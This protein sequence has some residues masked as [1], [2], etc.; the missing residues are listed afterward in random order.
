MSSDCDCCSHERDVPHQRQVV[1]NCGW[2]GRVLSRRLNVE[3]PVN[4]EDLTGLSTSISGRSPRER[5]IG[6]V[7]AAGEG[8]RLALGGYPKELMPILFRRDGQGRV[9]PELA[10]EHC[11]R[12][13]A[14]AGIDLIVVVVNDRKLEIL[15]QLG[16]GAAY[17]CPIVYVQQPQPLGLANAVVRSLAPFPD[18]HALLALP[19]TIFVPSDVPQRLRECVTG[20]GADLALA[21]FPTRT[22]DLLAP[23]VHH[24]GRVQ[25]V[26]EKPAEAPAANTWGLAAWSPRFSAALPELITEARADRPSISLAFARA[27]Y[28]GFAV[29]AADFPE[30]SYFDLGTPGGLAEAFRSSGGSPPWVDE[31]IA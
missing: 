20:A 4:R 10:I 15:R 2:R 6:I 13:L 26:L 24:N 12:A 22:P 14:A 23:V 7:P 29:S 27:V 16:D 3:A 9:V 11:L 5:W 19:D 25:A 17:G 31:K 21:V 28:R 8:R 18:C 1:S 30:G